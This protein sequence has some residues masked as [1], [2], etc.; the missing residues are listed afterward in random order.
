[1]NEKNS[2]QAEP[3][4]DL[5][6]LFASLLARWRLVAVVSIACALITVLATFLL[7]SPKYKARILFYVNNSSASSGSSISS[8]DL[9]VSRN[10]VDSYII[11][12]ETR[13]TIEEVISD[14][15][16][17]MTY[18]QML[19]MICATAVDS[20][21]IFQVVV[22]DTDPQ[23]AYRIATSI[24]SI[25]P[26]RIAAI[27]DGASASVVEAATVPAT[28]STPNYWLTALISFLAALVLTAGVLLLWELKD[29]TIRSAED[30]SHI[31]QHPVLAS[32]PHMLPSAKGRKPAE[33]A[34]PLIGRNVTFAASEAYK[35]L[36]TK[37]Q[38]SFAGDSQC[39][40]IS[41]TS[42]L[43]SEGKSLTGINIAHSL[44]CLGKRVILLDCDMRRPVI[45][46]KLA[47]REQPGL[48]S[49][50][51]GQAEL[52]E[53]IQPCDLDG[54][55]FHVL[56]AGQN[57]PNPSELLSSDRMRQALEALREQYDY[58][59]MDC[60]PVG[61]FSDAMNLA[62]MVDGTLLVVRENVCDRRA[63][64][65]AVGQFDY[66]HAKVLGFV[67]NCATHRP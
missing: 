22:T 20:T 52:T 7:I 56:P 47:L 33:S 9:A 37:L 35:L 61:E 42:A 62:H 10:L 39:R 34:Q 36:R 48:S 23:Q 25:L 21:E 45:A 51:T 54:G 46:G 26:Q 31:C 28:P 55:T 43:S 24:A 3:E 12:L 63:L 17:D 8:G 57:P 66:I 38:F 27:I 13:E 49:Y 53:L 29:T 11:I 67:V 44:A 6:R 5:K 50:L 60:P 59:I 32:I 14:V 19:D 58:I 1:M 15:G 30:V 18:E 40:A 4:V 41:L 2:T 16:L 64:A 65:D